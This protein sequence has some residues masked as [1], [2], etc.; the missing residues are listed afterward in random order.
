MPSTMS[1]T[2]DITGTS[3][4]Y[5]DP[6]YG[7]VPVVPDPISS[8]YQAIYGNTSNLGDIYNMAGGINKFGAQQAKGQYEANLPGYD[9][10]TSKASSDIMDELNGVVPDDV[11]AN[12]QQSA[13]E[14]GVATGSPQSANTG[15]QYLRA[16]GLTSLGQKQVGQTNLTE[17]IRRT[18][19]SPLFNVASMLVNPNDE[20]AARMAANL[21]ASAPNP[22]AA[23]EEAMANALAGV[24]AG[25]GG[26]GG[27]GT[28]INPAGIAPPNTT[29][30]NSPATTPYT[31]P[32]YGGN[33]GGGFPTTTNTNPYA[34]WSNWYNRI[35]SNGAG[36]GDGTYDFYGL[37][38]DPASIDPNTGIPYTQEGPSGQVDS[39]P[40]STTGSAFWWQ[41]P[42]FDPWASGGG[43]TSNEWGGG[44]GGQDPFYDDE[45]GLLV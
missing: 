27:G 10:M 26:G 39:A 20:Q 15:A 2:G 45:L 44:G 9:A 3:A 14:R 40:W 19:T 8:Q 4:N 16:L 41:D 1:G 30:G 35:P 31:T 38:G 36:A 34:N 23:A 13:A 43:D 17:A 29:A 28:S 18:P 21:Y 37:G 42:N 12:L 22:R 33:G 7:G 5:W 25:A 24:K 11:M 32:V 6:A